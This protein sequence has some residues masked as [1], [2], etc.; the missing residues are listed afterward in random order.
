MPAVRATIRLRTIDEYIRRVHGKNRSLTAIEM[1]V[2]NNY[3]RRIINAIRDNWPIDTGTSWG[4]W[5]WSLIPYPGEAAIVIE[6]PMNYTTYVHPAGTAPNPSA[7][8]SLASSYAGRLIGQEV[9]AVKAGLTAAL[10]RAIDAT[11]KRRAPT[12]PREVMTIQDRLRLIREAR[13]QQS[14]PPP[15]G[16]G[17]RS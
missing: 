13:G 12:A 15:G 9:R 8:G 1:A 11:E 14:T 17:V 3:A 10:K 2:A 7:A 6:N 5:Q 4:K 16:Q